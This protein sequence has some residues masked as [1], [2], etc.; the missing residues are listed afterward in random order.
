MRFIHS[1]TLLGT[2]AVLFARLAV[3]QT[4]GHDVFVQKADPAPKF[5]YWVQDSA[6]G[7]SPR[8]KVLR[9]QVTKTRGAPSDAA[10]GIDVSPVPPAMAAQLRLRGHGGAVVEAVIP[11]SAAE[12]AGIQQYDVIEQVDGKDV[13]SPEQLRRIVTERKSGDAVSLTVVREGQRRKIKV[14]VRGQGQGQG[15]GGDARP[16]PKPTPFRVSPPIDGK[17]FQFSPDDKRKLEQMSEQLHR[18]LEKQEQQIQ[19]M[20]ERLRAEME[21]VKAQIRQMREQL[22]QEAAEQK[23]QMLDKLKEK[24]DGLDDKESRGEQKRF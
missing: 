4:P 17:A 23:R 16:S 19:A 10:V 2:A 21:Q 6:D 9:A 13:G 12:Q 18:N 11:G 5:E 3:A 24:V 14:S 15:Q 1:S 20:T 22:K 7:Q 8:L